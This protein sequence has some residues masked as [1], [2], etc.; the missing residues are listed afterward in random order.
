MQTLEIGG[1]RI[2]GIKV[3]GKRA[4]RARVIGSRKTFAVKSVKALQFGETVKNEGA[5]YR[6]AYVIA[7]GEKAGV[8]LVTPRVKAKKKK[9]KLKLKRK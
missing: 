9:R 3:K 5:A 7:D 4:Y 1:E 8:V 2:V 6:V